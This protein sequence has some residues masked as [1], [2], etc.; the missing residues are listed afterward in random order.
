[1]HTDSAD[2]DSRT[3]VGFEMNENLVLGI[4]FDLR[5]GNDLLHLGQKIGGKLTV[6]PW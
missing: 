5:T 2:E 6:L 3:D 1:M 4:V